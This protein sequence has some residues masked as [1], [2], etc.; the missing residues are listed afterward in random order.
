MLKQLFTAATALAIFIAP[1]PG[2]MADPKPKGGKR[3][4]AQ[5]VANLYA[6]KTQLWKQTCK[7]G[8]YYGPNWQAMAW[9]SSH[10]SDVGVGKWS[11]D[12]NGRVCDELN[13]YWQQGSE[14][15]SKKGDKS[16]ISHLTDSEGTMWRNWSNDKDWWRLPDPKHLLKGFKFKYK[17]NRNRRKLGV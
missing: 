2:A 13:W 12:R 6:G 11:V 15:G 4:S 5:T 8:I 9:C 3:V 10:P 1:A 16:C 14:V 17:V 7:G